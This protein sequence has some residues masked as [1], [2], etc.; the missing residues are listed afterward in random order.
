VARRRC[1]G[2]NTDPKNPQGSSSLQKIL[3]PGANNAGQRVE[4]DQTRFWQLA[5]RNQMLRGSQE[6]ALCNSN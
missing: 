6:T 5:R 2:I 4:L 3:N 1:S